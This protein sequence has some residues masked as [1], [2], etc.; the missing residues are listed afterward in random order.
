[1]L[2]NLRSMT[3]KCKDHRQRVFARAMLRA[4]GEKTKTPMILKDLKGAPRP[5]PLHERGQRVSPYL[6]TAESIAPRAC[7]EGRVEDHEGKLKTDVRG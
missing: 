4:S 6:N 5:G 7:A 2:L 1:M 3:M